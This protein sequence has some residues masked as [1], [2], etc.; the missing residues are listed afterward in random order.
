LALLEPTSDIG[1]AV[2]DSLADA[3]AGWALLLATPVVDGA[4]WNA[5]I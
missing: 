1:G 5:E 3:K 2:D 4:Y